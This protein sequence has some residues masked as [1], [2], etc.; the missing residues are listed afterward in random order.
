[1]WATGH[2][3]LRY[4]RREGSQY[5]CGSVDGGEQG[6]DGRVAEVGGK[7]ADAGEFIRRADPENGHAGA[8]GFSAE[9][10]LAEL[11]QELF[12]LSRTAPGLCEI[13]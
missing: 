6:V 7:M 11:K 4:G 9:K 10:P 5:G 12:Q 3:A 8:A 2:R 1:M 13:N